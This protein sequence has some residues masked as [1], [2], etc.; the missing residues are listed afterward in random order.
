MILIT[1]CLA[2]K[3][4]GDDNVNP[5]TVAHVPQPTQLYPVT[6]NGKHGFIDQ[7]G[8]LKFTLP[9][10]VY[11]IG[12]FSE[13]FAVVAREVPNTHGRW[14]FIDQTGKFVIEAKFNNAKP[15]S[16]GLAAVIVPDQGKLGYI[17]QTG[18]IVIEPQF[19][20]GTGAS[21]FSFSEGLAAVPVA[22]GK[23]GYINKAGKFV[24]QPLFAHAFP[25]SE[26]RAIVGIAEP[27]Y[28]I[29]YKWGFIDKDGRWIAEP[30]FNSA[31]EF[32]E[33]LAAILVDQKVG[34]I[35]A[36]GAIVIKP[37]FAP[38]GQCPNTIGRVNSGRF[39]GGLAAVQVNRKW[40]FID[41][42]GKWIIKPSY[43]CVEP[44]SEGLS[45][46]GI[47]E[48]GHWQFG[49]IDKTGTTVIG[50]QFALAQSFVG[51][52]ALVGTG[53]TDDELALKAMEDQ[54]AGKSETQIKQEIERNKMK[55]G[56]IDKSGK[57]VWKPTN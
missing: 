53:M 7:T 30:R 45:L 20:I 18:R 31:S 48:Q 13:G 25:F 54:Q 6:I 32:S 33:G 11:T 35:D 36:Q 34:Y 8:N 4:R 16:E 41:R 1:C 2:C 10:D 38:D 49:Y 29:D 21:N 15:F 42:T 51:N 5:V 37:Q 47:R 19:G 14:G 3:V 17:D 56:Y 22:S 43:D 39:S 26:G 50:P 55:Y 24:I 52:L 12:T 57:L 23:W 46:V 27:A 44:F 40:G 28:S 9:D